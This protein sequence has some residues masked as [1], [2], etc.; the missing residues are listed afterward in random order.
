MRRDSC[1]S[2]RTWP[3]QVRPE[4]RAGSIGHDAYV[5]R[6][7]ARRAAG[8]ARAYS[9]PARHR[10]ADGKEHLIT[11]ESTEGERTEASSRAIEVIATEW[12]AAER[13]ETALAT[14]RTE[15]TARRLA[16][17]YEDAIRAASQEELRLAWEA[18][19]AAQARCEMGSLEWAQARSVSELLRTEYEATR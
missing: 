4:G 19:R 17:E 11:T 6:R 1:P 10:R 2:R 3:V 14:P 9:R 18:A 12:L 15:A 8:A 7:T 16:A 5:P 13:A